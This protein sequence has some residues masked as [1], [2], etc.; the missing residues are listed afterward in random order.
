MKAELTTPTVAEILRS[1]QFRIAVYGVMTLVVFQA[2]FLAIQSYG[3]QTMGA[4]NGPIEMTQVILALVAATGLFYAAYRSQKGRATIILCGA[5]V[6]YAAARE[7]DLLFETYLFDDAYKVLVGLPMVLLVAAAFVKY[8]RSLV[9][10][11]MW[12]LEQPAATLFALAGIYLCFVCQFFDRPDLWSGISNIT[13]A[14]T[15][16]ALIEEY[17]E[18]FAYMLLAFS[19][20][21]AGIFASQQHAAMN[22]ANASDDEAYPRIAA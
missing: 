1:Y 22:A 19:G 17:A 7:A 18:L 11:T 21:E 12:L 15:T 8:R 9:A 20:L 6:T 13:E 10:E 3:A 14:E 16:K 2:V 5:V 4:E